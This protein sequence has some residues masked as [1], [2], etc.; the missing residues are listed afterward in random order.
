MTGVTFGCELKGA[1]CD[2]RFEAGAAS[3]EV[4]SFGAHFSALVQ[5]NGCF[6]IEVSFL[7][8]SLKKVKGDCVPF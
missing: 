5:S 8:M 6:T 4:G 7:I 3:E 2:G 1:S